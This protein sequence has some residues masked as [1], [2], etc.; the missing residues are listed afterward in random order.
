MIC[1][2]SLESILSNI[3]N[4]ITVQSI[5]GK[6]DVDGCYLSYDTK[7]NKFIRSGAVVVGIVKRWT[8]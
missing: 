4:F 7:R 8:E 5:P 1:R 3:S 2:D 6:G